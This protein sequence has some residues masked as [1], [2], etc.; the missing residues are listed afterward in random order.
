M[1]PDSYPFDLIEKI[2]ERV[3]SKGHLGSANFAVLTLMD[4]HEKHTTSKNVIKENNMKVLMALI[5][6]S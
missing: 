4:Y 3:H 5:L 1:P 2:L 6:S